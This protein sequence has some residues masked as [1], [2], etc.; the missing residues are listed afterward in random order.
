MLRCSVAALLPPLQLLQRTV[1]QT[2]LWGTESLF[3]TALEL[4][5]LASAHIAMVVDLLHALRHFRDG[6]SENL[7]LTSVLVASGKLVRH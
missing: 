2:M 5:R 3:L 4:A 6:T 1:I 7:G